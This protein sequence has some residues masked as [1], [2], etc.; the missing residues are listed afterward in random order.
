MQSHVQSR[1]YLSFPCTPTLQIEAVLEAHCTQS[2]GSPGDKEEAE[3]REELE[4]LRRYCEV[5]RPP[6]KIGRRG[7][8]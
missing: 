3:A 7:L 6:E 5:Q 2:V 1:N 4:K 8:S